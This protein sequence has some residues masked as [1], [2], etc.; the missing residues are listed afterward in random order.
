MNL[1]IFIKCMEN[2]QNFFVYLKQLSKMFFFFLKQETRMIMSDQ[3]ITHQKL[4]LF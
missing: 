4:T 1:L 3:K 2:K